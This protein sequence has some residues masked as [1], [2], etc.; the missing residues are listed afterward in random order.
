MLFCKVV[1]TF[2]GTNILSSLE[3]FDL[4]IHPYMIAFNPFTDGHFSHV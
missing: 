3:I 2:F 4:S 1:L